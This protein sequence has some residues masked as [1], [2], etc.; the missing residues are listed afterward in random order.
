MADQSLRGHVSN[1]EQQGDLVRIAA[2][3]DPHENL[4]AIGWKTFDRLGKAKPISI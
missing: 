4:S 3:V 1:L 2:E